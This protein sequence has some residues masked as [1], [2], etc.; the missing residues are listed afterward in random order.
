M[1]DR[2]V[3]FGL[4]LRTDKEGMSI[5]FWRWR[6]EVVKH[7]GKFSHCLVFLRATACIFM[8]DSGIE[9]TAMIKWKKGTRY[10]LYVHGLYSPR[11]CTWSRFSS[12]CWKISMN[13]LPAWQRFRCM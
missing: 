7:F 12:F 4:V 5:T 3:N 10:L 9:S 6:A 11:T 8:A 2:K 1:D 13:F